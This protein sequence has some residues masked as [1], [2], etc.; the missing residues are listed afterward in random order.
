MAKNKN[1][2]VPQ[3]IK[4]EV[5]KVL[6]SDGQ[7]DGFVDTIFENFVQEALD[8]EATKLSTGIWAPIKLGI[9]SLMGFQIENFHWGPPTNLKKSCG[10]LRARAAFSKLILTP[11][12][13]EGKT[14]T[15]DEIAQISAE[16]IKPHVKAA[17]KTPTP[18]SSLQDCGNP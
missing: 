14:F 5:T 8:N 15:D 18:V 9:A 16:K 13:L 7:A 10:G 6:A 11:M 17:I 4:Q 12:L 2:G 3:E 1:Q